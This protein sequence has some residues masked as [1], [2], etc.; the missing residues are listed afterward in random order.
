MDTGKSRFAAVI[1]TAVI[2]FPVCTGVASETTPVQKTLQ[3]QS[4]ES[5]NYRRA[6]EFVRTMEMLR[7]N[8]VDPEKVSYEKLFDHAMSGMISALDPYSDY[9][10][11]SEYEHQQTRRTGSAVGIGAMAVKPDGQA[12]TIVRVLPGSPAAAAGLKPGD[13]ITAIDGTPVKK[14][15][16]AGALGKLRGEAGSTV[17]LRVQRNRQELTVKVRREKVSAPA[18]P[19]GSVKL[20]SGK[21]GFFKLTSFNQ[22]AP[23]EVSAALK[24]LKSHGAQ[25]II[26]DLRYNPGGLV[27]SAIKIASLF[28]PPGKVIFKARSRDSSGESVVKTKPGMTVDLSTPVVL[29]VNA[30]SASCS[31]ILAGALQDHKRAVILG[32]RTFGKGTI[33]RVS[34]LPTGGAVRYASAYYVTPGGRMIEGKGIIPDHE[35]RISSNEV[36]RLSTQSLRYPGEIKPAAGGTIRDHQL[37]EAVVLLQKKL[38]KQESSQ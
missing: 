19:A 15:N 1:L 5:F 3:A 21:I 9:E 29:L 35:V 14:L 32:F 36:F 4:E 7:K 10:K 30:F 33:L 11:A 20:L 28:L 27:D 8:Y 37:A 2:L 38:R 26:I 18:V 12:V 17:T 22:T 13:R 16:L 6:M 23:A 24:K 25:G 31:E 34:K